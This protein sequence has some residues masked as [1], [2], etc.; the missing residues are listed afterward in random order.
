MGRHFDYISVLVIGPNSD[1]QMSKFD[2]MAEVNE[3]YVLYKYS[4]I[5]KYRNIQINVCK[6]YLKNIK[7]QQEKE[8]VI[9][10]MSELKSI[11]DEEFYSRLGELHQ[12]DAE[13]NIIS[14]DNPHGRWI[15][16]EQGGRIFSKFLVNLNGQYISTGKKFDID[17]PRIHFDKHET[18]K[19]S[20]TWELCVDK[21][22]CVT[23]EDMI[24]TNNMSKYPEYFK[25]FKS[26]DDYIKYTCSFFTNAV[27]L[28]GEWFDMENQDSYEWITTYYD[29][30]IKP[31]SEDS[32]L[33]I[34]ECTK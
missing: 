32:L 33:T 14:T 16:C 28:N 31:L 6:E 13:K 2:E 34:Y 15:T 1:E 27:V 26:K 9:N 18:Q 21:A 11:S 19:Y 30:F 25:N 20:R 8:S 7:S 5:K 10:R 17:W 24:I 12:F 22:K 29:R 4:D 3:P 23:P